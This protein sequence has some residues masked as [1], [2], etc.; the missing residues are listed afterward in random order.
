MTN[1]V[2]IPSID[3][4]VRWSF[5]VKA[6]EDYIQTIESLMLD[7]PEAK[8][9]LFNLYCELIVARRK[10]EEQNAATN[11]PTAQDFQDYAVHYSDSV[12]QRA[13]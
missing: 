12:R 7:K 9:S 3:S 10:H 13:I 6:L 5:S 4:F 2:S 11:A 1:S 8:N